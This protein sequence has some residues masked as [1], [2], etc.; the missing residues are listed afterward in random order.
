MTTATTA[1]RSRT[2]YTPVPSSF[3]ERSIT[4]KLGRALVTPPTPYRATRSR[5]PAL[6]DTTLGIYFGYSRT[7]HFQAECPQAAVS[8]M[9]EQLSEEGPSDESENEQP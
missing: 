6:A 8:A 2:P 3:R 1:T 4:P 5:S 9:E 7:G